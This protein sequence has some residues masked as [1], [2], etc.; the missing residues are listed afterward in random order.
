MNSGFFVSAQLF[1]NNQKKMTTVIDA[2][3][4]DFVF[5]GDFYVEF[6]IIKLKSVLQ[7]SVQSVRYTQMAGTKGTGFPDSGIENI[8]HSCLHQML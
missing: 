6:L 7:D 4:K 3:R 1:Q 8:M 5:Y 2:K